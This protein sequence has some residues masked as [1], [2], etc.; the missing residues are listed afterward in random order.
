MSLDL[1]SAIKFVSL[2]VSQKW[3]SVN[4]AVCAEK[5]ITSQV[6]SQACTGVC[7]WELEQAAHPGLWEV[8]NNVSSQVLSKCE[9]KCVSPAQNTG[10]MFLLGAGKGEPPAYRILFPFLTSS[11]SI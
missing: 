8:G 4:S 6:L 11:E 10:D 3:V 2:H 1:S 5:E 9:S 7:L